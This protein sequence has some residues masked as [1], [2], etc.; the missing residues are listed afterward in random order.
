M[1]L[2]QLSYF[3][4]VTEELYFGRATARVHIARPGL[5]CQIQSP[6]KEL[7][8]CW[9]DRRESRTNQDRQIY[10]G[11]FVRILG[12]VDLSPKVL[13]SVAGNSMGKIGIGIV[14]PA[15]IDVPPAFLARIG[16]KYP[17][18]ELHIMISSTNDIMQWLEN[19]QINLGFI[20]PIEKHR[21]VNRKRFRKSGVALWRSHRSDAYRDRQ[22]P[23]WGQL[24]SRTCRAHHH[25]CPR[26]SSI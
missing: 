13:R 2:R 19:D 22:H 16:R 4:A 15:T 8:A 17:D 12:D 3:V 6:E 23:A 25:Q 24:E 26:L 18:I 5:S 10:Y 14:Y 20:R 7:S 1:G 11:Q 21:L 9:S